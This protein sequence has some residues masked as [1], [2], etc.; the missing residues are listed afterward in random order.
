MR[1]RHDEYRKTVKTTVV[2][3]IKIPTRHLSEAAKKFDRDSYRIQINDYINAID[4]WNY[5]YMTT[6]H[7]IP[8]CLKVS[9][10]FGVNYLHLIKQLRGFSPQANYT[11]RAIAACRQ[12]YCQLRIEGIAWSAQRNPAAVNLGFLEPE[13]LL[14][15]SSSSSVIL[16]RLSGP[17]SRPTASQKMW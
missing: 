6:L 16:T 13:P 7:L 5:I 3:S 17:R 1:R 11:D 14:L 12:S 4:Q 10:L 2:A 8:S 9:S 15:S